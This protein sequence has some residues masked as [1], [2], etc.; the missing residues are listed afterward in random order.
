MKIYN[1]TGEKIYSQQVKMTWKY[2]SIGDRILILWCCIQNI[3]SVRNAPALQLRYAFS[4]FSMSDRTLKALPI[5]LISVECNFIRYYIVLSNLLSQNS[6]YT[7]Q[8][9]FSIKTSYNTLCFHAFIF[10]IFRK[11]IQHY[12][13]IY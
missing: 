6:L 8:V 4:A 7:N 11:F 10:K 12:V 1:A 3:V 9:E 13:I 2:F 5:I